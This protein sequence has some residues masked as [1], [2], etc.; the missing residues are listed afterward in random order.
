MKERIGKLDRQITIARPLTGRDEYGGEVKTWAVSD[1]FWAGVV[2]LPASDEKVLADQ[3]TSVTKANF[4]IR[5][6]K[7]LN[8]AM[9]VV[10]DGLEYKILSILPSVDRCYMTIETQELGMVRDQSWVTPG[11][12]SWLDPNGDSW[13][14]TSEGNYV[15]PELTFS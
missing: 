2:Y 14:I 11:G 4:T 5:L 15:A 7:G 8:T 12:D 10:Y 9:Y 13:T 3:Q 1:A 6:R